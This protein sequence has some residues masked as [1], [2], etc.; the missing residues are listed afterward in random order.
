MADWISVKERL[1]NSA[2]PVIAAFARKGSRFVTEAHFEPLGGW[3]WSDFHAL[4][5]VYA[6]RE[7]PEAPPLPEPPKETP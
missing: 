5:D 2:R 6:W 3:Y 7:M 1:P 4:L